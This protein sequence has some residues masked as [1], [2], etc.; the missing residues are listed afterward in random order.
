M[1]W[2]IS[3]RVLS[4]RFR[5]SKITA[6]LL[7]LQ[8]LGALLILGNYPYNERSL[9]LNSHWLHKHQIQ[10]TASKRV[11]LYL[12][13]IMHPLPFEASNKRYN[14]TT[15]N[16]SWKTLISTTISSIRVT[17]NDFNFR[18]YPLDSRV[19]S[20]LK[21]LVHNHYLINYN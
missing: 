17:I 20:K 14:L 15:G 3:K 11:K 6:N 18:K 12:N 21:S 10:I 8:S 19:K 5:S 9:S 7:Y 13:F 4:I 2:A 1:I 16:N